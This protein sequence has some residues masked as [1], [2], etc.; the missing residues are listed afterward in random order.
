MESARRGIPR[1]E[2]SRDRR[3]EFRNIRSGKYSC[4]RGNPPDGQS[5]PRL[6]RRDPLGDARLLQITRDRG[7]IVFA[8]GDGA[9][10]ERREAGRNRF[11][12]RRESAAAVYPLRV[13]ARVYRASQDGFG[14]TDA[15]ERG[16]RVYDFGRRYGDLKR[17]DKIRRIKKAP[18]TGYLIGMK[19]RTIKI[20]LA[21]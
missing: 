10:S 7:G 12:V 2:I 1:G 13:A 14:G 18:L 11:A 16:T 15:A 3:F 17:N 21:F 19:A 20:V 5:G 8:A 4:A 9:A 6:R